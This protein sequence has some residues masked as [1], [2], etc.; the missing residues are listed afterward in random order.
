MSSNQT[1]NQ[2]KN[3]TKNHT[4]KPTGDVNKHL[5]VHCFFVFIIIITLLDLAKSFLIFYEY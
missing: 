1:K 4:K 2:T 3:H 5:G